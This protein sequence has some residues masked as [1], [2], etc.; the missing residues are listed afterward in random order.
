[1]LCVNERSA[2]TG[3]S[4]QYSLLVKDRHVPLRLVVIPEAAHHAQLERP[5]VYD[6]H[7]ETFLQE[8]DESGIKPWE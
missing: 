7:R 4:D 2:S 1:M 6:E 8:N 5:E 3:A